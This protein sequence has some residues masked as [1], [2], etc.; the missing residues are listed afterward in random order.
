[1][2]MGAFMGCL[3]FSDKLDKSG[4]MIVVRTQRKIFQVFDKH[5][6]LLINQIETDS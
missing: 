3:Y 6:F 2:G 5:I 1:M 4:E